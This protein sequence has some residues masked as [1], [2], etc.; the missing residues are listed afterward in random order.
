M[1]HSQHEQGLL[2][3]TARAVSGEIEVSALHA[4]LVCQ[5]LR[6]CL[7][8]IACPPGITCRLPCPLL[9]H[10]AGG[11]VYVSDRPG[12]HDFELLRRLVLPDGSVLRC[13]LPGRP[14]ADCLFADVSRDGATALKVRGG[15]C[16]CPSVQQDQQRQQLKA[17]MLPLLT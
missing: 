3:A 12:R 17:S 6:V 7:F 9:L 11:P 1:F 14:T 4:A 5:G 10:A 15:G 13:R 16:L 8:H 2:H